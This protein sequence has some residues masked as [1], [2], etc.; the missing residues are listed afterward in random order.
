MTRPYVH[1]VTYEEM[2]E[3]GDYFRLMRQSIGLTLKE[4]ADEVGIHYTN[5]Y[6]WEKARIIPKT[7]IEYIVK[8]IQSIVNKYKNN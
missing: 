3:H 5:L 8:R 2:K 6:R 4:M 1:Q 7:D